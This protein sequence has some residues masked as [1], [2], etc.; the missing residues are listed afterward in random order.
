[1]VGIRCGIAHNVE[2]D[3]VIQAMQSIAS[4]TE[5]DCSCYWQK[6]L[7]FLLMSVNSSL[8]LLTSTFSVTES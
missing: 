8:F 4:L 1:M 3:S 6:L 2:Q 5:T 7:F